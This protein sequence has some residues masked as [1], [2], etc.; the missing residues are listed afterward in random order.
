MITD[1][2]TI[3]ELGR[4]LAEARLGQEVMRDLLKEKGKLYDDMVAQV[5]EARRELHEYKAGERVYHSNRIVDQHMMD[6][7][8]VRK[9]AYVQELQK[10]VAMEIAMGLLRDGY[11]TFEQQHDPYQFGDILTGKVKLATKSSGA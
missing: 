11:I 8:L 7:P 9:G 5:L 4:A 3:E 6:S 10:Q 1:N 2:Q